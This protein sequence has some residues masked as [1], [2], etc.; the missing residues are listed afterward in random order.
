L[1]RLNNKQIGLW[2]AKIGENGEM[3]KGRREAAIGKRQSAMG[4]GEWGGGGGGK[5]LT[6]KF[7]PKGICR[8]VVSLPNAV[9]LVLTGKCGE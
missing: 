2:S 7:C 4:S 6:F 1:N 9:L 5:V 8:P 3:A